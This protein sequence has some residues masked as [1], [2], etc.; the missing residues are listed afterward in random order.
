MRI[1]Q[2]IDSLDPGGAE[3]MAVN[4]ANA[5]TDI[6]SFQELILYTFICFLPSLTKFGNSIR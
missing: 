4:Y 3:R 5:L 1:V 6:I 2:L